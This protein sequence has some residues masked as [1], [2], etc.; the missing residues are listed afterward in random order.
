M[1]VKWLRRLEV[2]DEPWAQREETSKYTDLLRRW[3]SASPHLAD[4]REIRHHQPE[5][6]GTDHA[7]PRSRLV[8]SGLAWSGNGK[9]TRVDVS[10]DGGR[11]W[12]AGKHRRA[13]PAKG[14]ASVLSTISSGMDR[15]CLIQSARG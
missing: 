11:N 1:W 14:A 15:K 8:I 7:W 4:G 10:I 5:P 12:Q 6:A 3:Q 2:G 9:I 13:E